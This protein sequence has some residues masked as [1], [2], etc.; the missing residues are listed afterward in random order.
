MGWSGLA[1]SPPSLKPVL[2]G[3][4]PVD[5][6]VA[7]L[8]GSLTFICANVPNDNSEYPAFLE[9]L[10]WVLERAPS[11]NFFILLGELN[12]HVGLSDLN[13]SGFLLL[14]LCGG[15]GLSVMNTT[16]DHKNVRKYT[17]HQDTLG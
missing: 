1:Y 9:P 15:H 2:L 3:F 6:R 16:F 14:D 5:G 4:S 8:L 10:V 7:S 13:L 17:W 11:G 12:A